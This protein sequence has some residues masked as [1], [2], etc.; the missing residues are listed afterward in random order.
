MDKYLIRFKTVYLMKNMSVE[1]T[2]LMNGLSKTEC[3][4]RLRETH[5]TRSRK[6]AIIKTK[7]I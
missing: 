6:I 7:K 2:I 1:R 5:S 4:D 3:C